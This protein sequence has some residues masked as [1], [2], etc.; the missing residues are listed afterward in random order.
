MDKGM[1]KGMD[2]G[3][4]NEDTKAWLFDYDR[5]DD[6]SDEHITNL[7]QKYGYTNHHIELEA[8]GW[9]LVLTKPVSSVCDYLDTLDDT[10][11]DLYEGAGNYVCMKSLDLSKARRIGGTV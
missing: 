3:M 4:E 6:L 7:K 1:D 2:N 8:D 9:Y 5:Y 10:N 11:V